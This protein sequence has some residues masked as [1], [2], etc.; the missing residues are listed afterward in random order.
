MET[1]YIPTIMAASYWFSIILYTLG[2]DS[3]GVVSGLSQALPMQ[4]A[5]VWL[6][7][8]RPELGSAQAKKHQ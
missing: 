1:N 8:D 4:P 6:R 3:L 7:A 2:S 5:G